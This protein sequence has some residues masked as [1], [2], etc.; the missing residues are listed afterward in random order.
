MKYIPR[1]LYIGFKYPSIEGEPNLAY[2]GYYG[3]TNKLHKKDSID[4]WRNKEIPVQ[5]LDNDPME[6]F[7]FGRKVGDGGYGYNKRKAW[8]RVLDPRGF[9]IEITVDN[10]LLIL[11]ESGCS[12]G[13]KIIG[14]F[15]YYFDNGNLMLLPTTSVLYEEMA[16]HTEKMDKSKKIKAKDLVVHKVYRTKNGDKTIY[17]GRF[18]TYRYGY[19]YKG[20]F[21]TELDDVMNENW[22][23]DL[24]TAHGSK[25][26]RR[27][28]DNNF[29]KIQRLVC[30]GMGQCYW[31]VRKEYGDLQFYSSKAFPSYLLEELPDSENDFDIKHIEEK[32][33]YNPYLHPIVKTEWRDYPYEEFAAMLNNNRTSTFY[34]E[35]FSYRSDKKIDVPV[36]EPFI[37]DYFYV[38]YNPDTKKYETECYGTAPWYIQKDFDTVRELYDYF[39]PRYYVQL[40]DN[41][42]I[43]SRRFYESY[44]EHYLYFL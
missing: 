26:S 43:S 30:K 35:R 39:N 29:N 4:N 7:I 41:G 25:E 5:E 3:E 8:V 2:V 17:L 32:L 11:K 12:A 24:E 16:K 37:S 34:S 9:E 44:T 42:Y 40:L 36:T 6:G 22:D 23:I 1:R 21:Y 27:F 33:L 31:F 20:K 10:L 19:V 18:P 14:K 28:N 15:V 13:G 38:E